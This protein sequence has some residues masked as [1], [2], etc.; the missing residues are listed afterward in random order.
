MPIT[1]FLRKAGTGLMTFVGAS[2][3]ANRLA[4]G[5]ARVG[6]AD[7]KRLASVTWGMASLAG[8]G[9]VS[10]TAAAVSVGVPP[11]RSA[12]RS[13]GS[14][15]AKT[16]V[17]RPGALA[18]SA[19]I[20]LGSVAAAAG[21]ASS[22]FHIPRPRGVGPVQHGHGYVSWASGRAGRMNPNHLGATG[23]LALAMHNTRHRVNSRNVMI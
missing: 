8:L 1:D 10:A 22:S 11:V 21:V 17:N 3:A 19:G 16:A 2:R 13:I 20:G 6:G 23:G 18:I 4:S 12:I 5:V 7:G 9:P 14:M 15:I